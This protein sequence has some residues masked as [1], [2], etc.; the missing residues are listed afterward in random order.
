MP[1]KGRLTA[2]EKTR[3]VSGLQEGLSLLEI[4]K[5]M[6]RD[7][8]TLMSFVKNPSTK[9]R[10]D[11]GTR[12]G[13]SKRDIRQIGRQLKKSPGCTSSTIFRRA[14]VA[15]L[16]RSTR[17]RILREAARSVKPIA[18]PLLNNT[19]KEKRISWANKYMKTNFQDV[20]FTDEARAT[21]DGPDGW[22]KVWVPIGGSRPYRLR[23]QQ[24][25][26]GV[27]FWAG[28]IGDELVGPFRVPEGVKI[29]SKSYSAFLEENLSPW[30]DDLPLSR[31]RRLIFMHD[32]APAHSAKATISYLTTL[33]F[34]GQ[35]L[36]TWPPCSPDLNPIEQLWS[37][38]KRRVY[39][40]GVQ[41]TSKDALWEKITSVARTITAAEIGRLTASMDNRLFKVISKHGSYVDK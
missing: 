13:V 20:L 4:A 28:I 31:S 12:R 5:E 10:K 18:R 25:G 36:M 14:G 29:N 9:Q 27:M 21:L 39:E 33:G 40:G 11:K 32:N 7:K 26:G 8:R 3:I 19:H 1:R 16:S 2:A 6:G 15:P 22:A 17:C 37:I 41:F 30:L 35:T 23:R 24:G 34:E 38:L